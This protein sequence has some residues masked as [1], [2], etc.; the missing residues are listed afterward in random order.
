[1]M[2]VPDFRNSFDLIP[3]K[4]L[5]APAKNCMLSMPNGNSDVFVYVMGFP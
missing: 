3:S 1:M 5:D 2:L 4:A